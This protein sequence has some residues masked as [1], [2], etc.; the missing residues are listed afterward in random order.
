MW[1]TALQPAPPTP[2]TLMRKRRRG[3]EVSGVVSFAL[4]HQLR[5]K[6]FVIVSL[7]LCK[8]RPPDFFFC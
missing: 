7:R 1:F 3:P 2:K 5:L 6:I 8:P 4:M